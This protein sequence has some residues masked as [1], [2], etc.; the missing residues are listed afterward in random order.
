MFLDIH[1]LELRSITFDE[2][3]APGRI[4]FGPGI[5]QV[6]P[7]VVQGS[8]EL[9]ALEIHLEGSLQTSV[10]VLCD[11]CLEPTR[12]QTEMDF[13]L[14]YRPIQTIAKSEEA[15]MTAD[16][17]EV[18]FYHG[19][20][21][22]LEDAVKEQILLALPMKNVCRPDCAG[23]CP[24]CGQNRNLRDCR[25]RAAEGDLRWAPLEKLGESGG[26]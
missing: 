2:N 12:R 26:D 5:L 8:A 15:D 14:F 3:L 18:G 21:L 24:Q 23:L 10:E 13:D 4:D 1:D 20:G 17:L 9:R 16:D 11:R 7:L 19:D 25:C 22:L 6:E